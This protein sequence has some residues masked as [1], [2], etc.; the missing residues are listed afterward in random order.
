VGDSIEALANDVAALGLSDIVVTA[1]PMPHAEIVRLQQEAHALLML[2][3]KP[4]V[5]GYEL[6]AGAKLFGY[7]KAGRPIVGVLP[8]G[9]AKKILQRVGVSTIADVD[10]PSEIIAVLRQILDAW[11]AGTLASL[12]PD[13]AACEVYSAQ[14][15]TAALVRAL[16]GVPA[17]EPFVPGLLEIP[18]S[19][20]RDIGE[21]GWMNGP[22]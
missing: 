3:R 19:L 16:E 17:V 13:R 20:Q 12:V 4:T 22:R 10:S 15:Q 2:E 9:E 21:R 6:L 1:S 14:R 18:L 8:S 11:A 5:K 7:L